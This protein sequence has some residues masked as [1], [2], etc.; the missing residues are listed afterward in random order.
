MIRPSVLLLA[1]SLIVGSTTTAFLAPSGGSL[2]IQ[3]TPSLNVPSYQDFRTPTC[4]SQGAR[5]RGRSHTTSYKLTELGALLPPGKLTAVGIGIGKFY[6]AS[7]LIAG[8]LTAS[9]KACFADSMAQY[10]DSGTTTFI[11]KR[12]L[13]MVLYS[14][15]VSGM[16]CT[17]MYNHLF[18]LIFANETNPVTLAIKMTLFDGFINAPLIWLPPAYIAQAV[19][20]QKSKREALQKYITDVRD[21]G[22][23]KKYWSVWLPASL[24]NFLFVPAHFR[25]AFAAGV[26]FFWI[27]ILSLVAN[28]NDQEV[29][30][31]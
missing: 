21:N 23:L 19:V 15:T 24:A 22:L 8:F 13:A 3:H 16:F 26:S 25:I 18:P 29:E 4:G 7:P 20:F 10:R 30:S 6:K 17:I 5:P 12:N 27:I 14:G 11:I 28:N 2:K 1:C 31:A 9:T